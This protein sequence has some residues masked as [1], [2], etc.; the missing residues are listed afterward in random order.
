M[1]L[2]LSHE[3]SLA[4]STVRKG[5]VERIE[6]GSQIIISS[7]GGVLRTFIVLQHDIRSYE[8]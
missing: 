2:V 6:L 8:T 1:N 4:F 7:T 5:F 3:L